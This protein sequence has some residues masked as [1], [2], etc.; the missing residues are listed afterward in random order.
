MQSLQ[1]R[2]TLVVYHTMNP[3]TQKLWYESRKKE[4]VIN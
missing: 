3:E 4:W 1:K 2:W